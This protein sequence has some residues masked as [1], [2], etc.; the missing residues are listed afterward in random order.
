MPVHQF[1]LGRR[2]V[3]TG[4]ATPPVCKRL[5]DHN[6]GVSSVSPYNLGHSGARDTPVGPRLMRVEE[7]YPQEERIRIGILL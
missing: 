3:P 6:L 5:N 7:V 2:S 1:R 4:C